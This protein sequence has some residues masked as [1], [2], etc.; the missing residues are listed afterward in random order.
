MMLMVMMTTDSTNVLVYNDDGEGKYNE[1][2][3]VKDDTGVA[4]VKK[5]KG[6]RVKL[7]RT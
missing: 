5:Y 4:A 3:E 7:W 2:E 1:E 6:E